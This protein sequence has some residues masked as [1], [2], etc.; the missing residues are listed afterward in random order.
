MSL[1]LFEV[2]TSDCPIPIPRIVRSVVYLGC[3]LPLLCVC[4]VSS[5][6]EERIVRSSVSGAVF[7]CFLL[8][9]LWGLF[10]LV[11][12]SEVLS[13]LKNRTIRSASFFRCFSPLLYVCPVPS[14]AQDRTVWSLVSLLCF[15]CYVVWLAG[16]SGLGLCCPV[17]LVFGVLLFAS[18]LL[19]VNHFMPILFTHFSK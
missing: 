10:F 17:S 14:F 1:G 2:G 6:C 7:S 19:C 15:A 12:L 13:G 9:L 16:L 8:C 5:S 11:S 3:F 4:P 18:N